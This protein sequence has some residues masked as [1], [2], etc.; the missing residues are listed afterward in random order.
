MKRLEKHAVQHLVLMCMD[1]R[2]NKGFEKM[3]SSLGVREY[4]C[5]RLA[6]GAKGVTPKEEA[7]RRRVVLDDIRLGVEKHHVDNI[8]LL[9]H[10]NCGK[11]A[12]EGHVFKNKA[13]E[14]K[15][16]KA[17]L[18]EAKAAVQKEF[19]NV[20]VTAYHVTVDPANALSALKA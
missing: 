20:K 9:T 7:T 16:H 1:F 3:L 6:G 8:V 12:S 5:L 4:D 14:R 15:F 18:A 11:Y 19:P 17:E 2:F 10:E 13:E